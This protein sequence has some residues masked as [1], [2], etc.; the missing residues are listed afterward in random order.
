MLILNELTVSGAK[1]A[2]LL[3]EV[4]LSLKDGERIGLTGP[5][6]SGKT[7]LIKAVMGMDG[8]ELSILNGGIM[9]DGKSI[10]ALAD[11]E[12]RNL[13][14]KTLGFIPQNPMT[15][16]FRNTRVGSQITETFMLHTGCNKSDAKRLAKD[17]LAKV[18]LTDTTRIMNSYPSQLSGGMLQR[19]VMAI[20]F[21]TK[22]SYI[23]ADEPTSALDSFNRDVLLQMLKEYEH[24]GILFISHDPEAMRTL[25]SSIYVMQDGKIIEIQPTDKFFQSPQQIW[26]KN[27]V[28]AANQREKE[29]GT[30][31]ELK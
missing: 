5:S 10:V 3:H 29:V 22:P 24:A 14:Q 18:N 19:I 20:I 21:G 6:G 8:S 16:F 30:W 4:S 1:N 31:K 17:M 26:T 25:C 12:R 23:L 27:F 28:Q 13:C 7:T 9:L 11:K 15:A 2:I